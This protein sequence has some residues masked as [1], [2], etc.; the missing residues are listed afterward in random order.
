MSSI[1]CSLQERALAR[2]EAI[3][4]IQ[5]ERRKL[6]DG[7]KCLSRP[8]EKLFCI[9]NQV[10][11]DE[12]SLSH[13]EEFRQTLRRMHGSLRELTNELKVK[14]RELDRKAMESGAFHVNSNA[15]WS[16]NS[17]LNDFVALLRKRFSDC[18]LPNETKIDP[19]AE[20]IPELSEPHKTLFDDL[21][22]LKTRLGTAI[23]EM[24]SLREQLHEK[25]TA[26]LALRDV[27]HGLEKELA[28]KSERLEVSEGRL[29]GSK[30]ESRQV[31]MEDDE[32]KRSLDKKLD[33]SRKQMS[34]RSSSRETMSTS[35]IRI[36][37]TDRPVE[38]DL[39]LKRKHESLKTQVKSLRLENGQLRRSLQNVNK[40]IMVFEE[41]VQKLREQNE[42]KNRVI[43][44]MTEQAAEHDKLFQ[45][46]RAELGKIRR[47][48]DKLQEALGDAREQEDDYKKHKVLVQE[49]Q[50]V[51]G[52][53][54]FE[55]IVP[56]LER[57][58]LIV[59]E[60]GKGILRIRTELNGRGSE[61]D[62]LRRTI[63]EQQRDLIA[64]GADRGEKSE[65]RT[66]N[67]AKH[68]VAA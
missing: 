58:G 59:S 39:G 24:K 23:S 13:I 26:L 52:I 29:Q 35:A 36:V 54:D 21:L 38:I 62:E 56:F 17:K 30:E 16:E 28:L 68:K 42:G 51:L 37:R 6:E 40:K 15:L 18:A 11:T 64:I 66:R 61:L 57:Q 43:E 47:D 48:C 67:V 14:C 41:R 1:T 27:A 65:L 19:F 7:N 5:S 12:A 25:D 44:R 49:I 8:K 31:T 45:H 2:A 33:S 22:N 53:S 10:F 4:A 46:G 20:E 55:A 9:A 63:H 34:A 60:L 32:M 3:T 50:R